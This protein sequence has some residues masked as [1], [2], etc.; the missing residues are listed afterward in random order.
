MQPL[1]EIRSL[2]SRHAKPDDSTPLAGVRMRALTAPSDPHSGIYEPAFALV[3]QGAKRTV[4][5]EKVLEYAA[6]QYLVVPVDLP[7][8]AKVIR[9]SVDEPYL[10]VAL[11]LNPATITNLLLERPVRDGAAVDPPGLKVSECSTELLDAVARL[12]RLLDHPDDVAVLG[13]MLEREILW[14]LLAGEQRAMVRQIG[15]TDSRLS[16]ISRAI[17]TIR[18][19]YA[20]ALRVEEL[21]QVAAMSPS[22]FHRHFLAITAMSPLQYQKT[23]RLQEARVRLIADAKNVAAVG[24]DVGYDSPS[25]FSREYRRLFGVPPGEDMKRVRMDSR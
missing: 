18:A 8:V 24:F 9:A 22:T 21:A 11:A 2:I 3:A 7:V 5:G 25:Q 1:A 15:L 19:H 4:V 16:Q 12:L 6:G 23:I 20:E 13:P 17:R 10:T 14:R